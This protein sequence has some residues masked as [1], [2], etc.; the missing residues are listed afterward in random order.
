MSIDRQ[1]ILPKTAAQALE[2]LG[3]VPASQQVSHI[4]SLPPLREILTE[5]ELVP[6]VIKPPPPTS[7]VPLNVS[8]RKL[9]QPE[10]F[11]IDRPWREVVGQAS[12]N[13]L[14][15]V[16]TPG[17]TSQNRL[18]GRNPLTH[19]SKAPE[20][21]KK[22][23]L[24]SA[25]EEQAPNPARNAH[26]PKRARVDAG[27]DLS[28]DENRHVRPFFSPAKLAAQ[29]ILKSR[30]GQLSTADVA[31]W[32][33]ARYAFARHE[34][35]R[36]N[37]LVY[38]VPAEVRRMDWIFERVPGLADMWRVRAECRERMLV[39]AFREGKLPSR[40]KLLEK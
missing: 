32:L 17:K 8:S 39:E 30:G 25:A 15:E 11:Q 7:H 9:P 28:L 29:A 35:R 34:P 12:S 24:A 10:P 1:T 14:S 2:L 27:L 23:C 31:G 19:A 4:I 18:T 38:R 33:E 36:K 20:N 5:Q 6:V 16:S 21:P 37:C 22:R 13:A 3:P 26:P 40:L